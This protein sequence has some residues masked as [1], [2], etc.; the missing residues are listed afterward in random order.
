MIEFHEL[1]DGMLIQNYLD[2]RGEFQSLISSEIERLKNIE[3]EKRARNEKAIRVAA[4][5][6]TNPELLDVYTISK[7]RLFSAAI[8]AAATVDLEVFK[9]F[10]DKDRKINPDLPS[11]AHERKLNKK[12][13]HKFVFLTPEHTDYI[14]FRRGELGILYK[15]RF[16]SDRDFVHMAIRFFSTLSKA[17]VARYVA[18]SVQLHPV[19]KRHSKP[20]KRR[21]K[22]S[23]A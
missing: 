7:A 22:S 14:Q 16:D 18:L 11:V 15:K 21:K 23:K 4:K 20:E 17:N 6:G 9:K 19:S 12:V 5:T 3:D 8:Y 1:I 2:T 10:Y 13:D